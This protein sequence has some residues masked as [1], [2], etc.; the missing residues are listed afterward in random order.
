MVQDPACNPT[1]DPAGVVVV[2]ELQGEG[3]QFG[4]GIGLAIA[5]RLQ[6]DRPVEPQPH[7]GLHRG[8]DHRDAKHHRHQDP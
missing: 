2:V 7:P 6:G 8:A 3:Q 1:G 4:D 5:P